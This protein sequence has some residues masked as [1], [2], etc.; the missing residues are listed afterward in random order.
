MII[1]RQL[2]HQNKTKTGQKGRFCIKRGGFKILLREQ[3]LNKKE[4]LVDL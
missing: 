4:L 1:N 2:N 3:R